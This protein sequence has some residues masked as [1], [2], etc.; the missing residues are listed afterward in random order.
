MAKVAERAPA[1]KQI[2]YRYEAVGDRGRKIKGTVKAPSQ[3]GAQNALADKGYMDISLQPIASTFS[4][5]GA[6]PSVFGVKQSSI[7]SFS[8]QL[9]TLLESGVSLLPALQLLAQQRSN[10]APMRRI[11]MHVTSDLST[12]TSINVALSRHP[13]AF[14]E[15]YQ[16]S[17]EVGERTGRLEEVLRQLADHMEK[18]AAFAKKVSGA[19]T[20]PTIILVVGILVTI[21]LL[22]VVLPPMTDLFSAFDTELPPPTRIMMAMS[23]GFINYWTYM[24]AGVV[25]LG[26]GGTAY[27]KTEKGKRVKDMMIMRIPILGAPVLMGEIARLGRT[28]SLMLG[29]GLSLQDTMELMPDTTTNS[30]F[31]DGLLQ[32][33]RR[34]FLGQGLSLPMSA[35]EIFPPLMLQMVRVGE[36]SNTLDV[37]MRVVADF[38]EEAAEQRTAA[39]V[40]MIT[41]V[42][43]ILLAGLVGFV[44]LSVIM[45]MYSLTGSF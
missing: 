29:A 14:D 36:E 17:I 30:V 25:F 27:V 5:E 24:L 31:R 15:I 39:L 42:S 3:I 2:S 43:T 19:M 20:Y 1:P 23:D 26:V 21:I 32:V 34:L 10:S 11:L 13:E 38:Y 35:N 45:P 7:V 22:T 12:G 8:R 33:R 4:L 44:A 18:R 37:T 9:A 41:P 28:M 40:S 6:I 16:R